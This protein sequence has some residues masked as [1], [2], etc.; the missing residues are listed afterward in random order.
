MA[1]D[2]ED[3]YSLDNLDDSEVYDLILQELHEYADLDTDMIEIQVQDGFITLG[4]RV[5][6]EQELQEIESVLSD[7]LGAANYSNEITIAGVAR[8]EH[9]EAAD[10]VPGEIE[11]ADAESPLGEGDDR[12]D[13]QAV[14]L[15]EDLPGELYGTHDVQ[16][17]IERAE[18]YEPLDRPI[19][20]GSWSEENH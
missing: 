9:S 5:G 17:A 13:P 18:A 11:L 10:D 15:L 7:V 16:K 19:Q 20:E 4:G 1:D 8:T 6:T 12:T 3:L 2:F 14:H